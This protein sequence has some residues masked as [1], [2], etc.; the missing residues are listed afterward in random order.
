[1]YNTN[2]GYSGNRIMDN[3][4]SKSKNI[5]IVYNG[6]WLMVNDHGARRENSVGISSR[7]WMLHGD[8]RCLDEAKL[9]SMLF[10]ATGLLILIE[11]LV[12]Y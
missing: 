12:L 11:Q 4:W 3:V 6:Y 7:C 1:M 10:L 2:D 5:D 9:H 8:N